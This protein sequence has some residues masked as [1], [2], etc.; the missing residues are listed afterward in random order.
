MSNMCTSSPAGPGASQYTATAWSK[1]F[2]NCTLKSAAL[3]A[4]HHA[5]AAK[6]IIHT[7]HRSIIPVR[8]V[9]PDEC[10]V[11]ASVAAIFFGDR[12]WKRQRSHNKKSRRSAVRREHHRVDHAA[13]TN[14][15]R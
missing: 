12:S 6:A 1:V 13:K 14:N 10:C 4:D 15:E 11:C 2:L 9:G 7:A 8:R 5:V 3:C